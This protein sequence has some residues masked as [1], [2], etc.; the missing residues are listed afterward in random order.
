MSRM[1]EFEKRLEHLINELSLE[2]GS[3]TPDFILARYLR[4]CLE[5]FDETVHARETWYGRT[6]DSAKASI[7][8]IR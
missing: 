1:D 3:N 8:A 2:N 5:Q 6:K 4:E 7:D